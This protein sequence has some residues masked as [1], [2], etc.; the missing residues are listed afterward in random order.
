VRARFSKALVAVTVVATAL[1]G[2]ACRRASD[3]HRRDAKRATAEA[4]ETA[5]K[6]TITSGELVGSD[7]TDQSGRA[8]AMT[9]TRNEQ[10]EYR[11]KL[12]TALDDLD[13]K[14]RDAKKRGR[15]H[16]RAIDAKR[17][18]LKHHLV[19]LDR[20]T[21]AEW[22]SLKGKIDRDLADHAG[23]GGK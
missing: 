1:P 16:V 22:A 5:S 4:E 11:R 15:V 10:L 9:A 7:G 13:A 2:V 17:D 23:V 6:T 19:A 18:V 20:T 3:E 14:R 8:E 12:G 21:D